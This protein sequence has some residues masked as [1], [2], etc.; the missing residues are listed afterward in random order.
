MSKV[1]GFEILKIERKPDKQ[2]MALL[3]AN[4]IGMPGKSM[5]YRHSNVREKVKHF[6]NPYFANLS[7]GNR[8]L[9]SVC[10]SK[11]I[12]YIRGAAQTAF[13]LRYFTFKEGL[14]VNNPKKRNKKADSLIRK[15]VRKLM[16]GEGLDVEG[17]LLL[18][19]YVDPKNHRSLRLIREFGFKR[20][21]SFR[22]I[23]FSRLFPKMDSRVC[24]VSEQ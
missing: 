2:L 3:E 22:V 21:S 8:L 4:I 18:Y 16:D 17:D 6:S 24:L 19:A 20:I 10:F 14:R 9:G 7:I 11:R 15:D 23:P 5:V 13:Y 1:K 12:V